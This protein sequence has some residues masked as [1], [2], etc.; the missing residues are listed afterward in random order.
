VELYS[1]CWIGYCRFCSLLECSFKI[2]IET[3]EKMFLCPFYLKGRSM[4]SRDRING[5]YQMTVVIAI[6]LYFIYILTC[7]FL[8]NYVFGASENINDA[9][10]HAAVDGDI[11]TVQRLIDEGADV[12]YRNEYG[13]TALSLALDADRG[14]VSIGKLLIENGA[15]VNLQSEFDGS[16]PLINVVKAGGHFESVK[17]LVENKADVNIVNNDGWSALTKAAD[18]GYAD[19]AELLI[20]HGADVTQRNKEGYNALEIAHN[21]NHKHIEHVLTKGSIP[22]SNAVLHNVSTTGNMLELRRQL[23]GG[24]N[25][26]AIDKDGWTPLILASHFGREDVVRHLILHGANVNAII[27][28]DVFFGG[29]TALHTA[30]LHNHIEI[31]TLLVENG[32][33]INHADNE[34]KTALYKTSNQ[35]IKTLLQSK[36]MPTKSRGNTTQQTD[37]GQFILIGIIVFVVVSIMG[38]AAS[39]NRGDIS[40]SKSKQSDQHKKYIKT[41]I[42]SDISGTKS[43]PHKSGNDYKCPK[44][45]HSY[46][47]WNGLEC[48]YCGWSNR[49]NSFSRKG[50]V[51]PDKYE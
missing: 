45:N 18:N 28:K 25:V 16:T 35:K 24:I 31:V 20:K 1:I 6:Q 2:Q 43:M 21:R 50:I 47:W 26:N 9:L 36:E 37:W 23:D 17:L 42:N 7:L 5:K 3:K 30:A 33:D 4:I 27:S 34:G 48:S 44:C 39:A 11:A 10:I 29:W 14:Y 13:N 32:A 40:T 12:K 19:I 49:T 38:A 41:E 46:G 8:P 15:D 51:N 22:I